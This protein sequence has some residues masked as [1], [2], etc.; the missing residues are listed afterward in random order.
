MIVTG[1]IIDKDSSTDIFSLSL[2]DDYTY[3]LNSTTLEII[4]NETKEISSCEGTFLNTILPE[5]S[6]HIQ[7]DIK[8]DFA[9]CYIKSQSEGKNGAKFDNRLINDL[10]FDK[11]LIIQEKTLIDVKELENLKSVDEK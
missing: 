9:H 3:D 4:N 2:N 6:Y 7:I 5:F 10:D 1:I 8:E 11:K